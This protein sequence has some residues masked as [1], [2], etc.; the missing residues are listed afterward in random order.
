[1]RISDWSSDV[2]S[3]DLMP[4]ELEGTQL[5]LI[6][7]ENGYT[8]YGPDESEL[9]QGKVGELVN[10]ELQG[11]PAQIRIAALTA[12]P[13]PRSIVARQ[14][15]ISTTKT[16]QASRDASEKGQTGRAPVET[17]APNGPPLCHLRL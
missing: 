1:M 2:C 7:T 13:G 4:A 12:K 16:L 8:L 9:A 3:S 10:F 15:R 17:P 14:S 5:T 6:A 11:A